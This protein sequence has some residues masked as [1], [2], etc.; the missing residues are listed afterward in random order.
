MFKMFYNHKEYD[1]LQA[2]ISSEGLYI[3][4]PWNR[5]FTPPANI[6]SIQILDNSE[7]QNL[8][9]EYRNKLAQEVLQKA[10]IFD[11]ETRLAY[12]IEALELQGTSFNILGTSIVELH[13]KVIGDIR[14]LT[15]Y[16]PSRKRLGFF[17]A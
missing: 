13:G 9:K 15:C 4:N 3:I 7:E 2:E 11:P 12:Q 8:Y 17:E 1:L 14:M 5:T 10:V 6:I 16:E